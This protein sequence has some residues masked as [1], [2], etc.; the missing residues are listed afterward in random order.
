M[1]VLLISSDNVY[2]VPYVRMY[3]QLFEAN[4][5]EYDI[6][7]WD[8]NRN[9]VLDS[10]TYIRFITKNDQGVKKIHGYMQF[11][12]K[13]KQ[14]CKK[15][16]Y[17]MIVPL[18]PICN[19][20]LYDLLIIK[21]KGRFVFDVRDY[22]YEKYSIVC[23]ME[24]KLVKKSMINIISSEGYKNF[25]PDGEY[26][27]SHNF[28]NIEYKSVQQRVKEK[29]E[30][31]A[32]SCI[33]LIRF[34]EENKKTILFF[35]NDPRFHLNFIGTHAN[36]LE[37]FCKEHDVNNVTLVDTFPPDKT[38]EI[39][40]CTDIIMN[41]YGNHTPLL[42]YALSNKLYFVACLH[43]PIL[44]CEDTYMKKVSDEYKLGF[45][46]SMRS[47]SEKD[48][49]FEYMNNLNQDELIE[50]GERFIANIKGDMEK[51]NSELFKRMQTL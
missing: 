5:I 25:L 48:Q 10:N 1:R 24:K 15:N 28:P 16:K 30:A 4:E 39:Y 11:R 36:K 50:N 2:L 34:M 32:I 47:P 3:T 19:L 45:T 27:V 40:S 42:D 21:Y 38:L 51:L 35:R 17:D 12:K 29:K 22:S 31:Y 7:Y 8:K 41:L 26:Y 43:K 33:G 46:M 44:V 23:S 6:I 18:H 14:L 9:E 49:L 13:I 37:E 20:I